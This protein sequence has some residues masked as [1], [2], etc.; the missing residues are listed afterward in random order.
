MKVISYSVFGY[1]GSL[2]D[3]GV[4]LREGAPSFDV[5][6]ISDATLRESRERVRAACRNSGMEFPSKRVLVSLSPADLKKDGPSFDLPMALS[7]LEAG[8]HA[9]EKMYMNEAT[10]SVDSYEGWSYTGEDGKEYNAVDL[11]KVT[12]VEKDKDGNWIKA[13]PSKEDEKVLVLGEL[14][15]NGRLR[16][17]RGVHAAVAD[18]ARDGI[19]KVIV[20]AANFYEASFIEG[21]EVFGAETLSDAVA[22]SRDPSMFAKV[23]NLHFAKISQ[24]EII[25][26][27][28]FD[29]D[30][31]TGDKRAIDA[32]VA[33]VAGHEHLLLVG[34]PG[35]G[36]TL[37]SQF[38]KNIQPLNDYD[39]AQPVTRIYSL[40]GLL[41]GEALM[42][43]A[44]FRMP[45]QSASIEGM[46]G[47]GIR[48]SPGEISL[49][50]NGVLFLDEAQ[51]FN[52]TVISAMRAA[53]EL[54]SVQLSRAGRSTV[55]P[56]KFTLMMTVTPPPFG[57]KKDLELFW[58]KF[59]ARL[60]E[61]KYSLL[62]HMD[63]RCFVRPDDCV[64]VTVSGADL[65]DR[66][67]TAQLLQYSRQGKLNGELNHFEVSALYKKMP[68]DCREKM[69]EAAEANGLNTARMDSLIKTVRTIADVAGRAEIDLSDVSA[70]VS[71]CV[72]PVYE[73]D[74][75]GEINDFQNKLNSPDL[76]QTGDAFLSHYEGYVKEHPGCDP[77]L[78]ASK[79]QKAVFSDFEHDGVPSEECA[80][81]LSS[82][83][84]HIGVTDSS[85]DTYSQRIE[86][87]LFR[88]NEERMSEK[89]IR[90]VSEVMSERQRNIHAMFD[91]LFNESD[92]NPA[93][94]IQNV[95]DASNDASAEGLEGE[96]WWKN[97]VDH[98]CNS[99]GDL[100]QS[101]ADRV[102]L[103]EQFELIP[104]GSCEKEFDKY[105]Q[106]ADKKYSEYMHSY[107]KD[108][109]LLTPEKASA[110]VASYDAA[111]KRIIKRE[112]S[113]RER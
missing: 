4:D 28:N 45:H 7:I 26:P 104:K 2:V 98:A 105:W 100:W 86:A 40:A 48:C 9:E 43:R 75:F 96:R 68:E 44:P 102:R 20:P 66:V 89:P 93:E 46:F 67:R 15:L 61:D 3:V 31:L 55:Y 90:T 54:G 50:H 92:T 101:S 85:P 71:L 112:R 95:L 27:P 97:S 33:S 58:K 49:A 21:M 70:A 80:R 91:T 113:G 6:G 16:P 42:T 23:D 109:G 65:R 64:K 110:A 11:G 8:K 88:M 79:A 83:F 38:A 94:Y 13:S 37:I 30:S 25:F 107:L 63:L 103:F 17:V 52:S 22:A 60:H 47:G 32:M 5:V 41:D 78:A 51:E 73:V 82:F 56:A 81:L 1:A 59:P 99:G 14:E 18:A 72:E 77:V 36:K 108:L 84:I 62:D 35:C 39:K 57:S 69:N 111:Q 87:S 34:K 106:E 19:T 29:E 10:G 12:E 53:M 24:N 74:R 76:K